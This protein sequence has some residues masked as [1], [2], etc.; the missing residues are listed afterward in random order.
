MVTIVSVQVSFKTKRDAGSDMRAAGKQT[1]RSLDSFL[2]PV[3]A[4]PFLRYNGA[5]SPRHHIVYRYIIFT[6]ET[7]RRSLHDSLR[8]RPPAVQKRPHTAPSTI[9]TMSFFAATFPGKP[10][11]SKHFLILDMV[12]RAKLHRHL[13]QAKTVTGKMEGNV[14]F[15]P[16][17]RS[18][19]SSPSSESA[20]ST[21]S[22]P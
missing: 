5:S 18:P 22:I 7:P 4:H 20:R 2:L 6:T 14:D 12:Q 16:C 8:C 21:K 1:R 19:S 11:H 17:S 3:S 9:N 15:C 13:R 10:S